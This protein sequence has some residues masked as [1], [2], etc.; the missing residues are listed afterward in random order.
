MTMCCVSVPIVVRWPRWQTSDHP[1]RTARA[2]S[3]S[4]LCTNLSPMTC[5]NLGRPAA[6]HLFFEFV[7]WVSW[8]LGFW[9]RGK[10]KN[11]GVLGLAGCLRC[12]REVVVVELPSCL[13]DRERRENG[14]QGA[15]PGIKGPRAKALRSKR[16]LFGGLA[17][18]GK[19]H[20]KWILWMQSAAELAWSATCPCVKQT[21][22]GAGTS[23]NR[24]RRRFS[25]RPA[26]SPA[27]SP[28][29]TAAV[30]RYGCRIVFVAKPP[31]NRLCAFSRSSAALDPWFRGS[32]A[33]RHGFQAAGNLRKAVV[34]PFLLARNLL[35][36]CFDWTSR[37]LPAS[38]R[39]TGALAGYVAIVPSKSAAAQWRRRPGG[40]GIR[41]VVIVGRGSLFRKLAAPRHGRK[42]PETLSRPP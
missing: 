33:W 9:E 19:K 17:Y 14:G 27:G 32:A 4:F 40:Q 16:Q 31:F 35:R 5:I 12:L 7:Y 39:C 30:V 25:G 20:S 23:W 24:Q 8:S 42:D 13:Q 21:Q 34:V 29:K 22:A 15:R 36:P 10:N 28:A 41:A 3:I 38:D 37:I 11:T 2:C 26:G 1:G 18:E 6:G